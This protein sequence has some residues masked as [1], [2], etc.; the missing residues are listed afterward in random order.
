MQNRINI[1]EYFRNV[2]TTG[3]YSG[4]CYSVGRTLTIAILGSICGLR[5]TSQIHQWA[6]NETVR[7]FLYEYYDITAVPCYFWFLTMLK[8]IKPESL[9]QCFIRWT[10]ALIAQ[11]LNDLTI[12]IGWKDHKIHYKNGQ[13]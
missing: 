2:E 12:S 5:N 4:Y 10:Q 1:T 6:S 13:L 3:E 7:S 9:N 11:S 8:M